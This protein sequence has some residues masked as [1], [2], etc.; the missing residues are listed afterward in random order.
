MYE[1]KFESTCPFFQGRVLMFTL[2]QSTRPPSSSAG[3]VMCFMDTDME[4]FNA[5]ACP[6]LYVG[7]LLE[8]MPALRKNVFGSASAAL[9]Q[10]ENLFSRSKIDGARE[11]ALDGALSVIDTVTVLYQGCGNIYD[12]RWAT[13]ESNLQAVLHNNTLY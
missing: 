6:Y 4:V 7:S 13:K 1:F 9:R 12:A 5:A 3:F 10:Q 2:P 8:A 11:I